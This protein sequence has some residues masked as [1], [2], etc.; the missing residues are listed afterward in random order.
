MAAPGDEHE[1]EIE[2]MYSSWSLFIVCM[3]LI[4][5]LWT[6]YYLQ[7]K[8]IRAIHETVVSIFAGMFVGLLV[9]I[10]PAH[11]IRDML[12]F[13]HT[14][15]FNLLLPPIILNSGFELRQDHFF[16]NFGAILTFAFVGTFISAVGLGLL[17]YVYAYLGLE[18]LNLTLLECL[19][20]GS[21]LSAT[22]PV[23]I[24]AIFQQY[25]VD[26][27]LYSIIFGESLLNDAVSIVLYEYVVSAFHSEEIYTSHFLH[28][29]GIFL[30]S[31][32]TSMALGVAF[33]LACSLMLKHSSLALFPRIE[34]C[35]VA[36]IAYTSYFF[37]NGLGMSGIVSLLFCGI[38][39]KHYAYHTMSVRTQR[40]SK[41]L[42]GVLAQLSE[43]F[44][45]IYL[46]LNLFTLPAASHSSGSSVKP[47][48]ILV[49]TLA[50]VA[51][52]YA[53]VFPL[54]SVINFSYMRILHRGMRLTSPR[55]E[56]LPYQYQMMLFWA[57][58]RG[59]VGVALA[60][61]FTGDNAGFLR[62]TVLAVVLLTVVVF[63]GT[64]ARMME[65]IGIRT[66]VEDDQGSSDEDGDP[67]GP[68]SPASYNFEGRNGK[69]SYPPEH[70]NPGVNPYSH[71]HQSR[72]LDGT[73]VMSGNPWMAGPSRPGNV[74]PSAHS[75]ESDSAEVFPLASTSAP[76][77]QQ[78]LPGARDRERGKWFV[79][80]DER[81]LMPLFSNATASRSFHARRQARKSRRQE[82]ERSRTGG[83]DLEGGSTEEVW[84][85]TSPGGPETHNGPGA[86]H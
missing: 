67:F 4:L 5:S 10:G 15:F 45:F 52:R 50:V 34:S 68:H 46:G 57:G 2:E 21:A 61:G 41:Y 40:T 30:L 62:T 3:L 43:N 63:G 23:T 70:G 26:P 49:S 84:R 69:D 13:K 12:T 55:E 48:L 29:I 54:S 82:E 38:T 1:V 17:V 56:P 39:L 81:Y 32:S 14:L 44:I 31:F 85:A 37:S 77:Q 25:K 79:D 19:L 83:D 36:L 78:Q 71:H 60:A 6:S 42:F 66:G 8:R 80:L 20:F 18:S 33:G 24:L 53:A 35:L 47:L 51:T 22:D 16:R 76:Q 59:A 58:L 7:I 9:R 65:I 27:T 72:S 28:G 86:G 11:M 74:S 64:T 75:S 73:S